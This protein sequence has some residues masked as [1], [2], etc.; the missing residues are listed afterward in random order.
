MHNVF[1]DTLLSN[2]PTAEYFS[3]LPQTIGIEITN[4]CSLRCTHC[5]N[6]SS[7]QQAQELTVAQIKT[8]LDEMNEWGVKDLRISGGEPTCH[9]YFKEIIVLCCEQYGINVSLNSNGVYSTA[10]LDF[11]TTSPINH[12]IISIDGLEKHHDAIRQNGSFKHAMHS[13]KTLK[14]ANKNVLLSCHVNIDNV[15]DVS[16]LIA[17]AATFNCDVKIAP[18]R[19]LGRACNYTKEALL[20]ADNYYH[21]VTNITQLRQQFPQISILTD[22]DILSIASIKTESQ[23]DASKCSCKAGRTMININ[24]DGEIYPCAF[25]ITDEKKFSAGNIQDISITQAW[26]TAPIFQPFRRQRKAGVC[27]SCSY[28]RNSCFAGCPAIAY[29]ATG[30]LDACDPRCFVSLLES[31]KISYD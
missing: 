28:Y 15:G 25:F 10:M 7:P 18:I 31:E 14:S 17:L 1:L 3:P 27:Q 12:C 9:P 13:C 23:R 11:L 20:S 29:F 4:R 5:F 24:Y 2:N 16:E 19:F 21:L 26:H 22:F 6:N 30:H 8:I